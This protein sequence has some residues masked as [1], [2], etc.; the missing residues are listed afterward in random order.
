MV[1][2]LKAKGLKLIKEMSCLW[3]FWYLR[4]YLFFFSGLP[5]LIG[6]FLLMKLAYASP[7]I[8]HSCARTSLGFLGTPPLPRRSI[9]PLKVVLIRCCSGCGRRRVTCWRWTCCC[10]PFL[11]SSACPLS[12]KETSSGLGAISLSRCIS[13]SFSLRSRS[14][15]VDWCD[16]FICAERRLDYSGI[17]VIIIF[18]KF[19]KYFIILQ[20]RFL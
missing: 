8:S 5:G 7:G 2:F 6:A 3:W 14:S 4:S 19:W 11:A 20:I 16:F 17:L 18:F 13:Y 12:I 1:T 10:C 9:S 15:P